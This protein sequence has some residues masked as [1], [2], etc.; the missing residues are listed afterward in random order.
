MLRQRRGRVRPL[1][2]LAACAALSTYSGTAL[3]QGKPDLDAG[4]VIVKIEGV[5][6]YVNHESES[7]KNIKEVQVGDPVR[8]DCAYWLKNHW[9]LPLVEGNYQMPKWRGAL[10]VDGKRLTN[11]YGPTTLSAEKLKSSISFTAFPNDH[12][13]WVPD[14]PKSYEFRCV[15][16][17][18][19]AL[20]ENDETNNSTTF[21]LK[22]SGTPFVSRANQPDE[23]QPAP[24]T[25]VTAP[26]IGPH[27]P[28]PSEL[29]AVAQPGTFGI[30]DPK[31]VT[32]TALLKP[33]EVAV[34]QK[35]QVVATVENQAGPPSKSGLGFL[36]QC[37][38]L[39]GQPKCPVITFASPMPSIA[40]GESADITVPLNAAWQPGKYRIVAGIDVIFMKDA[41]ELELVVKP[42]PYPGVGMREGQVQ[43]QGDPGEARGL[44]PQPEPPSSQAR[45]APRPGLAPARMGTVPAFTA[46]IWDGKRVDLCLVW[47]GQCGEP[48]ATEFCKRSGYAKASGWKP[49]NDIGA[50]TPT[51]VL[52]S[53]Q[54]CSDSSCDG[55]ASI[56]CSK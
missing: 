16:D 23:A 34:G 42:S 32:I 44:N 43:Q 14:S 1:E 49:A 54:V 36:V 46:P 25:E 3:A 20:E 29:E 47:G 33:A 45:Q 24:Q 17:E 31:L 48:A 4:A 7:W 41:V 18:M 38:D 27:P 21:V 28:K 19:H 50:Q 56:T 22:V 30:A 8:L 12:V 26:K 11:F 52:S 5:I 39:P 37:D 53:G 9:A 55:F 15:V 13:A 40:H 35:P 10:F 2:V 6:G 51:V